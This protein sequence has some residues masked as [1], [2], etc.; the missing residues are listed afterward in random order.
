MPLRT[1]AARAEGAFWG[2]AVRTVAV[3]VQFW[4]LEFRV[5]MGRGRGKGGGGLAC[6]SCCGAGV[7]IDPA[8]WHSWVH[9]QLQ[10]IVQSPPLRPLDHFAHHTQLPHAPLPAFQAGGAGGLYSPHQPPPPPPPT[11]QQQVPSSPGPQQPT[12]TG[13]LLPVADA[14]FRH[15]VPQELRAYKVAVCTWA[16]QGYCGNGDRCSFAHGQGELRPYGC[17]PT[18]EEVGSSVCSFQPVC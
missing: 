12:T 1:R 5:L 3:S 7:L 14:A 16:A 13:T 11:Q 10:L 4:G 9:G 8:T 2:W 17:G 15:L 6:C 18:F